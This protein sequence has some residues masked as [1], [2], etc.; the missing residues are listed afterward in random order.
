MES[1]VEE[2]QPLN[3]TPKVTSF[4][5]TSSLDV[6]PNCGEIAPWWR[7]GNLRTD[8]VDAVIDTFE[9]HSNTGLRLNLDTPIKRLASKYGRRDGDRLYTR[10]DLGERWIRFEGMAKS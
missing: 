1:L 6:Y 9:R 7:L 3:E 2:E 8:G 5:V 10:T 4:L